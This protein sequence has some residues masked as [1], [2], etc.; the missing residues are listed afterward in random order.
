MAS[1]ETSGKGK[2]GCARAL[3]LMFFVPIIIGIV[4]YMINGAGMPTDDDVEQI[5]FA[6]SMFCITEENYLD[7]GVVSEEEKPVLLDEIEEK[8][9][10]MYY[11]G[12]ITNYEKNDSCVWVKFESG[13]E[14]MFIPQTEGEDSF[15][16]TSHYY[17]YSMQPCLSM[18]SD[19]Y[20]YEVSLPDLAAQKL[21]DVSSRWAY[22]NNLDNYSVSRGAINNLGENSI[23]VW[24]GHGAWSANTG[25]VLL[26]G[27]KFDEQK[28]QKDRKYYK[29]FAEGR[30]ARTNTGEIVITS[31]YIDTYVGSLEGSLIYLGTCL[32]GNDTKLSNA[33]LNKGAKA[34]IVNSD[35]IRT[36]YNTRMIYET[37]NLFTT[38]RD[39]GTYRTLEEALTEA[40]YIHGENDS[41]YYGGTHAAFP[42]I[43]TRSN[44]PLIITEYNEEAVSSQYEDPVSSENETPASSNETGGETL[45]PENVYYML[46]DYSNYFNYLTHNAAVYT[47]SYY[48]EAYQSTYYS[49]VSTNAVH[50]ELIADFDKDG[51]DELLILYVN[52]NQKLD[53]YM[54]EVENGDVICKA[55]LALKAQACVPMEEGLMQAMTFEAFG[56]TMVGISEHG[57]VSLVGDGEL[58]RFSMFSYNGS[59]FDYYGAP[60]FIGSAVFDDSF[61]SEMA[62]LGISVNL[63]NMMAN[64][65]S[66][67][68]AYLPDPMIFGE[69]VTYSLYEND[70]DKIAFSN[71]WFE[72]DSVISREVSIIEIK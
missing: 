44:D 19:A 20:A 65:I 72:D 59:T 32:S 31:K 61:D 6:D 71:E 28:F 47:G 1:Y 9:A 55:S 66:S 45:T 33:F 41:V 46:S 50:S 25:S 26:I 53:A 58:Y 14:Y 10:L 18:Y 42:Y 23:I 68:Y 38:P 16:K 60:E 70:S 52:S 54:Y 67:F 21:D 7:D 43:R 12:E 40:K 29:E 51:F 24:H 3:L 35:T 13:L 62:Q 34:V 69:S 56:K 30:L 4:S 64:R 27:E 57:S 49:T 15:P 11:D 37:M 22:Y 36:T 17:I 39:D 5:M 48:K 63:G 8:A 2:K